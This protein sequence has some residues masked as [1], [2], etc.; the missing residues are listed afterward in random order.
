MKRVCSIFAQMLEFFPRGE[1]EAAV[2]EKEAE[3]HAR[4]FR[5]WTQ[6]VAMMF[7]QLGHAQSLREITGGLAAAEGRLA[8]RAVLQL[9][10]FRGGTHAR[11]EQPAQLRARDDEATPLAL[12]REARGASLLRVAKQGRHCAQ[13]F[14][15]RFQ[16]GHNYLDRHYPLPQTRESNV[17][18]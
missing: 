12:E 11:A 10:R 4:G 17:S 9:D 14:R 15:L 5:C 3:R 6:F 2:R 18:A 13:R 16:P 1:F 8:V 7:C